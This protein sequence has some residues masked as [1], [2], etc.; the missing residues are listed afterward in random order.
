MLSENTVEKPSN[1]STGPDVPN[2]SIRP[3]A[4][5]TSDRD[6]CSDVSENI[7]QQRVVVELDEEGDETPTVV[8]E[9]TRLYTV[10]DH[11]NPD[12][13]LSSTSVIFTTYELVENILL[14]LSFRDLT[15]VQRVSKIWHDV[16]LRSPVLQQQLNVFFKPRLHQSTLRRKYIPHPMLASSDNSDRLQSPYP[17]GKLEKLLKLPKG[18]WENMYVSVPAIKA[19]RING[20]K[21]RRTDP[22]VLDEFAGIRLG[23]LVAGIREWIEV[24]RGRGPC[25][26]RWA[27]LDNNRI[28]LAARFELIYN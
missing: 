23:T 9:N 5:D 8:T 12:K 26:A 2:E 11:Q 7:Q 20:T 3:N 19:M 28:I 15:C 10:T 4:S 17:R 24:D 25:L 1:E 27:G 14:H 16:T 22:L 6:S 18:K 13:E 21:G